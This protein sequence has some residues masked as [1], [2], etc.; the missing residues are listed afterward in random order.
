MF[1]DGIDLDATYQYLQCVHPCV[2]R[3]SASYSRYWNGRSSELCLSFIVYLKATLPRKYDPL[4]QKTRE[5]MC[6]ISPSQV[7]A[8][9]KASLKLR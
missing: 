8:F 6:L 9:T 7:R 3:L 5:S 2:R 1:N 4:S